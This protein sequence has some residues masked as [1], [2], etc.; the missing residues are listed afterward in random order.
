MKLQKFKKT[1]SVFWLTGGIGNQFFIYAASKKLSGEVLFDLSNFK[2]DSR[3]YKLDRFGIKLKK[4]TYLKLLIFRPKVIFILKMFLPNFA[5]NIQI[6]E[7]SNQ[8]SD[9]FSFEEG[10]SAYYTGYWQSTKFY[11]QFLDQIK[12]EFFF[13][14]EYKTP[15]YEF[16]LEKIITT[17]SVA[18]HVRRADYL[19]EK[20]I[21]TFNI[22]DIDYYSNCIRALMLNYSDLTF[23]IFS[24]DT[25]WVKQKIY[26][27]DMPVFYVTDKICDDIIEFELIR[28]SR[29]IITANST[30]S[31]WAAELNLRAIKVFAPK[32]YF[33]DEVLQS[34]YV[35]KKLL[36]NKKFIY[37]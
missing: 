4:A 8:N 2:H 30:F 10:I 3:N 33:K 31:W 23:F 16:F 26:F 22:L 35:D 19:D 9:S 25:E 29:F 13:K 12:S 18:L 14:D 11:D 37:V 34:A 20:N 36:F 6:I 28:N 1:I 21:S 7:V 27:H 15:S 32:I 17:N 24:E 5:N